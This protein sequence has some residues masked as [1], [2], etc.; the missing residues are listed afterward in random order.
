MNYATIIAN[1]TTTGANEDILQTGTDI[2]NKIMQR[3]GINEDALD[4]LLAKNELKMAFT[5]FFPAANTVTINDYTE[6]FP[7]IEDSVY[8]TDEIYV[9]KIKIGNPVTARIMITIS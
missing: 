5:I 9:S 3:M 2:R 6:S 1:F 7:L 8:T 4:S